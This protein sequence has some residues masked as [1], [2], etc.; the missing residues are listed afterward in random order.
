[1]KFKPP[2]RFVDGFLLPDGSGKKHTLVG[3]LFPQPKVLTRDRRELLLDEVLGEGFSVLVR[4]R[5][6]AAALAALKGSPWRDLAARIVVM[7]EGASQEPEESGVTHVRELGSA[8]PRLTRFAD[9][10]ILLRPDRYVMACIPV[11]ELRQSGKKVA[12]M[13]RATF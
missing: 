5:R 8:N 10:V 12:A 4:S 3:K 1:M 2:P 11:D 6:G 9:H 7:G 13:M